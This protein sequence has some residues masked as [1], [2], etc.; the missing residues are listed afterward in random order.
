M[1]KKLAILA[2]LIVMAVA[3][4]APVLASCPC[5]GGCNDNNPQTKK[6]TYIH[7]DLNITTKA[8][9]EGILLSDT[10]IQDIQPPECEDKE[11]RTNCTPY[12]GVYQGTHFNDYT[13]ARGKGIQFEEHLNYNT[14]SENRLSSFK[15][16]SAEDPRANIHTKTEFKDYKTGTRI[17]TKNVFTE[18][19]TKKVN[20]KFTSSNVKHKFEMDTIETFVKGWHKVTVLKKDIN[21]EN[22]VSKND[23]A[24]EKMFMGNM[25]VEHTIEMSTNEL[26]FN[27]TINP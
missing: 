9:G 12:T 1:M 22:K 26:V 10:H 13:F 3:M 27:V 2:C 25:T 21:Q 8:V 19:L 20:A 15:F 17:E 6:Y 7:I 16:V 24:I 18:A 23:I 11:N 4:I 14:S 5:P